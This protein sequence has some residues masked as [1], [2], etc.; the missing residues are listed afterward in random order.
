MTDAAPEIRAPGAALTSREKPG[1]SSQRAGVEPRLPAQ[2][3]RDSERSP[4]R[5][6]PS[7]LIKLFT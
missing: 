6:V 2:R 4:G 3:P 7:F 1:S 5:A